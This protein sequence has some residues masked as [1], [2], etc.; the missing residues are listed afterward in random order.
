MNIGF[1]GHRNLYGYDFDNKQY[2]ELTRVIRDTVLLILSKEDKDTE[3]N[4]ITGG[5]LGMDT[6]SFYAVEDIKLTTT[7]KINNAVAVPFKKQY[8]KWPKKS[9][10]TYFDMLKKADE[11]IFVD[12]IEKYKTGENIHVGEYSGKK[13]FNRNKFISD[14]SDVLIACASDMKSGTGHCIRYFKQ[15]HPNNPVYL[16]N[17]NTYEVK[18]M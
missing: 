11:V 6:K 14:M 4:T 16:I 10:D 8:I 18:I 12:T 5:A 3:H 17:P 13:M 1:T 2:R 7:Y 15:V 9:Q